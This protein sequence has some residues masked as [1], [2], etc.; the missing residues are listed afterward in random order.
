MRPLS[1]H[2][3]IF[4]L[5]HLIAA[6]VSLN[7]ALTRASAAGLTYTINSTA[8]TTKPNALRADA[9][10]EQKSLVASPQR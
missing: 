6:A 4:L 1:R 8:D 3:L 7:F 10:P 5:S 9:G 2:W